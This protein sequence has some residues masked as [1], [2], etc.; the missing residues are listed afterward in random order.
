MKNKIGERVYVDFKSSNNM[1]TDGT[2]VFSEG[3][4]DS[5]DKDID[6]VI[7]RFDKGRYF[8]CLSTRCTT[9]AKLMCT[10]ENF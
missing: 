9:G 7:G 1:E 10:W 8:D 4:I 3:Q 6:F 5:V 2:H